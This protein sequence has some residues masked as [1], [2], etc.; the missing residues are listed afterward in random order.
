MI[1]LEMTHIPSWI[2]YRLEQRDGK[3]TKV[4][5]SPRTGHRASVTDPSHWASYSEALTAHQSGQFNGIGFV[6]SAND[7]YSGFTLDDPK[8]DLS[9]IERAQLI[10]NTFSN[11][12]SEVSP[13]GKGI[14]IIV[15]GKIAGDGRRR[16]GIEVYSKERYFT[17]TGATYNNA[18]ISEND[19][20]LQRLWEELGGANTPALGLVVGSAVTKT[21]EEVYNKACSTNEKFLPLWQGN[22][23]QW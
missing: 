9:S 2:V 4:P 23:A 17:M 6:F 18:P 20:Y 1:P 19:Y 10:L 11:T 5:Y 7:P 12:Y 15:R 16:G 21:D 22:Y 14:H 3:D 13:S 8:G